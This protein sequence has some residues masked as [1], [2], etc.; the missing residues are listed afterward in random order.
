MTWQWL[1]VGSVAL[2][3][4]ILTWLIQS[5]VL[6]TVGLVAGRFLKRRGPAV[7]SALYRTI[8]V[9]VLVCPIA[10]M[11]IAAMGFPGLVIRLPSV[12]AAND[13]NALARRGPDRVGPIVRRGSTVIPAAFDLGA[14][15]PLAVEPTHA[16]NP[17]ALPVGTAASTG[18]PRT[19]GTGTTPEPVESVTGPDWIAPIASLMLAFWLLGAAILAVRLLVGYRRMAR[20]RG[21]AIPAEPEAE[22]LCHELARRM[23]LKLPEVLRSP[24]LS[25]PCLAG[26]QR[27]AIL[28]PEDV[29]QN[30]R[31]TFVHEL[32]HLGRRDGLWN[33]LRQLA[34]SALWVQPLL[35]ALS[36][37]IEET[38]E[39]VCDDF[40][41]AL[42]ADRGRYAGHLLE[43]AERRLPPLAASGVG[44]ISLRSL[45]ARRIERILDSTRSLSTRAGRRTITATLLAGLAG[46]IL[47]G[48][49][50]VGGA[51]PA[52]RGDEKD[53]GKPAT[54]AGDPAGPESRMTVK[55]RVV[56]AEGRPVAGATVAAARYRRGGV[57][58]YGRDANRQEIDRAMT[59][60]DG[61]FR[62]TIIDSA[63]GSD[64]NPA[65]PE[66]WGR[67][68]IV[69][70]A[71]GFG[72]AWPKTL[73]RELTEDQPISLVRDDV[74]ITGRLLDLEGRPVAGASIR[75]DSL[76][77][78]ENPGA[79]DKWLKDL[80]S[81]PV[82]GEQPRS[83][84]FPISE[85]CPGIEAPVAAAR[86]TTDADGRFRLTGLGRDRLA[87]LDITGP[88]I[89]LRRV[90]VVT[91][92]MASVKGRHL[93]E[94]GLQD[95]TYYGASPTI[96]AEPGRPI[97]GVVRDAD[98]QAPIPGAVVTAMNR[99]GSI[100]SIEGLITASTDAEGRYR[101]IG[102]PKGDGHVLSV[103]PSLDQPYFVTD[104]LKVPAGPG[105]E[106][107]RFDVALHRG[108]WIDGRVT[109]AKTGQ[110]V[111]AAI[112]YYP[113]LANTHARTFPNF[114]TN[115]I[116]ANWTGYRYHTDDQ[117][118]F[119]VVGLPGLGIVAVNSFARSYQLGVGGDRLS[120]S[121]ARQSMRR[122]ALPTYNQIHP[123]DFEAVSEVNFP[124][125]A[126]GMHQDVALQPTPSLT[127]DLV[128]PEGNPLTHV[129]AFGRFT[130]HN[131][132]DPNL[133][134]RSQAE[135]YGLDPAKSRTVLF[136]HRD[137]K[138]GAVLPIK[139]GES[140]G[141]GQRTVTL[142]ACATVTGRIVDAEG[143][144]V[145]GGITVQLDDHGDAFRPQVYA[146]MEPIGADGRFR[147]DN[148]AGG[149][150]YDFYA[151]DRMGLD[152]SAR[153]KME[154][155]RFQPF[156]L[157]R[158]V[159][160][161]PGQVIDL[162]TFSAATGQ[163]IKTAEQPEAVKED[164]RQAVARDFPIT[165]RI[166]D[167]EGRPVPGVAVQVHST[168][169]AKGGDLTPW[170]EAVR[171]GEPPWVAYKHL[172]E[173][174]EKPS[175]KAETDAQG[176]FRIEG[177][178]AE[179]VVTLSIEGPTIAH[180]HLDVVTRRVEPFP[181]QGFTNT[182]GPGTQT[183]YGANFTLSAAPG[184]V[185]EG[186][187]RD[188]KDKKLMTDVGVWSYS[189]S[190]SNFGGIM[191]LKTRSDTEGRFRLAGFPK[192]GKN[193]LLVVPNDDQPY[194][195]QEVAM[196]D[197]PGLGPVTVEVGLHKGIR[198]E[199][200]LTDKETGEPVAG[201][202]LHYLPFLENKFALTVPEFHPGSYVDGTAH[203]GRYL[204]K[205]D[206]TFRL[207]GLPG[208]AIVGAVV[209][210]GKP[211]RRGA[212]SESIQ[213]MNK[214]GHFATFNNPV[215]ASRHFPT[216]MK[217]IDP[218]EG[219]E[220]VHLDLT[221][222]PGAKVHLRVVDPQGKPVAGVKTG[223]RRDRGR[224][225]IEP[226]AEA[227]FDV[228]TLGPGEDRMVWLVHEGRKLGR[229]IHVKEGD[230][231]NGAVVVALEPSATIIGRIVDADG[232]PVSGATIGS[233][234]KPGGDFSLGLPQVAAGND[235]RF[236]VPDVP[237]GCDYSLVAES[238]AM[239]SQRRFA[240]T[241]AAVRPGETT[242]IGDIKLKD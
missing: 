166:V 51:T 80:E 137:R 42:G 86:A 8:L 63:S 126:L 209:Y 44:M 172:D 16:L 91:R 26:L 106:P 124:K 218:A 233:G 212:G 128:D 197:P 113:Y 180:T 65:D 56:D 236:T 90:Q 191:T 108:V 14:I 96:V 237:T 241:D 134:D 6:L 163:R 32:A 125:D 94:P 41:V 118:R 200:K 70:W 214:H 139:P 12:A 100:M 234:V 204:S 22:A 199:G 20:L 177:L 146:S 169:K 71:P 226:E 85:Q 43:L 145:T 162:G 47:A 238:G 127:I 183:I 95:A 230:D 46:T 239:I 93:D 79:V 147:I 165:G 154:P 168:S 148:L 129:M 31:D 120:V 160:L 130:Q 159:N 176:R 178:G 221:L 21:T 30:L 140:A 28:L 136:L 198:I 102:L 156:E 189:F 50:G 13:N 10:S 97:E 29:E 222:D 89:A 179:K 211:Y 192:G 174:K 185:V 205:A 49:L 133:Y 151:R 23:R 76:W 196:P 45:L 101:L 17:T 36:R 240:F 72:P 9:A 115:S 61:R 210:A 171:R 111:R 122:V 39:E 103:Y 27:P 55:G 114:R 149:G 242:D 195:M 170:I 164:P 202:W 227:E 184:R 57:G 37:R 206:G 158:N 110:P 75:V 18:P 153:G 141:A 66:R 116:S 24:F 107:V 11:A 215:M 152:L 64:P 2:I 142:Q 109:D 73:A 157:A 35:W 68:A 207:V 105:I 228:V 59:D 38:A 82:D 34:T 60:A 4:G 144:P 19:L 67:P 167:L 87:I 83:H 208:R 25:S 98:T 58:P 88:S 132:G 53:A 181:A 175:G 33:L 229:V 224:Y 131:H 54:A 52:V 104:F 1:T 7:Q 225:D 231:K 194:F 78:A 138:L 150:T 92:T 216:S 203:Q 123:Q 117:G 84:Y 220:T 48:L 15:A 62:V 161:E 3:D 193:R 121:L 173:D 69:A 5:T 219:T 190:G 187:V 235:G 201:A 112:H 186:V 188:A 74:P 182:Y 77:T 143:K 99:S 135:V 81:G 232:N 213:G 217:E 155:P 40:V 223:G 119:R